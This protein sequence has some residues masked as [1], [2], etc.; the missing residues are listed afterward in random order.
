MALLWILHIQLP[1]GGLQ[2]STFQFVF[3]FSLEK[4]KNGC[5]KT[6]INRMCKLHIA[7]IKLK[8]CRTWIHDMDGCVNLYIPK[9]APNLHQIYY[10]NNST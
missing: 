3:C 4:K 7:S 6:S 2:I 10:I 8:K 9:Y 1:N 5:V